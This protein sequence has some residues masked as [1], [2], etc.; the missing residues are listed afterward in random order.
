MILTSIVAV[1]GSII[2][3]TLAH[4]VTKRKYQAEVKEREAHAIG[5]ELNNVEKAVEIWRKLATDLNSKLEKVNETCEQLQVEI[6]TLRQENKAMRR[7]NQELK[8][9]METLSKE[10]HKAN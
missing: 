8:V 10:L 7:E 1:L 6:N 9:K 3:A 2:S 4:L 5:T